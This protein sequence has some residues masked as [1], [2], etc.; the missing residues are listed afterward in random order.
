M[1]IKALLLILCLP[2]FM[3]AQE[4]TPAQ[5]IYLQD[6]SQLKGQILT[7]D[8]T[9]GTTRIRLSDQSEI[10]ISSSLILLAQPLRAHYQITPRGRQILQ[11]GPYSSIAFHTLSAKKSGE[12]ETGTRW[13]VGGHFSSGYQ[14][15][16]FLAVG[17]GFGLDANEYF[18]APVFAELRGY[19]SGRKWQV[20][21][22]EPAPVGGRRYLPVSYS[23]QVGYN[24]P[25][26]EMFADREFEKV[27]GGLLFYPSIGVLFPT[28][29]GTLFQLDFGYKFQRYSKETS[30]DW[31]GTY[32]TEENFT[33]KS[34]AIRTGCIF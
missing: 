15:G 28:R 26:E 12:F 6:G 27:K 4:N 8:S 34:L 3:F 25:I 2:V 32:S 21:K 31:W 24:L 10:E 20:F 30:F 14:F 1:K 16:P 33:L 13:D 7:T 19:L 22:S 18:F 5:L 23:L 17:G 9:T 11:K 29:R